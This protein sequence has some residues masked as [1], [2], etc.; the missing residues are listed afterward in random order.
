M[1]I[2]AFTIKESKKKVMM[3]YGNDDDRLA[4]FFGFVCTFVRHSVYRVQAE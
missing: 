1:G 4:L 2:S 3:V